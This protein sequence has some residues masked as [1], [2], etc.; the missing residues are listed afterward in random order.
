M[1]TNDNYV[2]WTLVVTIRGDG[3][4]LSTQFQLWPDNYSNG[5]Y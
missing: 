3:A 2:I 1:A 4:I 5:Q